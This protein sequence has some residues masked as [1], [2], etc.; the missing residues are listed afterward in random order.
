M[1]DSGLI[2]SQIGAAGAYA[3]ADRLA[4]TIPVRP[5]DPV[6]QRFEVEDRDAAKQ[7]AVD[8]QS[9]AEAVVSQSEKAGQSDQSNVSTG[10]GWAGSGLLGAF[11]SFLARLFADSGSA[12]AATSTEGT[13]RAGAQ[14]Y[15][16]TAS[17]VEVGNYRDVDVMSPVFPRLSS[18]RAVDLSV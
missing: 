15:A 10:S 18:G 11:T 7:A 3:Q 9:D 5:I 2:T 6:R 14:A 4:V 13:A 16:R 12:D 1:A 17:S 8:S